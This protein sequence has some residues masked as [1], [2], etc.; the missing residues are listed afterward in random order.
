MLSEGKISAETTQRRDTQKASTQKGI[1]QHLM[2]CRNVCTNPMDWAT[3]QHGQRGATEHANATLHR[4]VCAAWTCRATR[5]ATRRL[6]PWPKLTRK[7][8]SFRSTGLRLRRVPRVHQPEQPRCD[9]RLVPWRTQPGEGE[10]KVVA[11]WAPYQRVNTSATTS[12]GVRPRLL[13]TAKS[14]SH[15]CTFVVTRTPASQQR[16]RED[17]PFSQR[18]QPQHTLHDGRPHQQWR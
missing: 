9:Q 10:T 3:V 6:Y 2:H 11:S 18:P 4:R 7:W 14:M 8:P 5:K 1:P 13:N 17:A 16:I 12:N 15:T